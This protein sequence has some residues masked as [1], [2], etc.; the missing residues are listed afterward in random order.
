MYCPIAEDGG[1]DGLTFG[2]ERKHYGGLL[3]KALHGAMGLS[4]GCSNK[5]GCWEMEVVATV[6]MEAKNGL[7][8]GQDG[9]KRRF[10]PLVE[11]NKGNGLSAWPK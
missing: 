9:W 1:G 8:C 4:S 2:Q 5:K 11:R 7:A 3:A 10:W 6:A